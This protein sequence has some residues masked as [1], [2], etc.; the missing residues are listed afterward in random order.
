MSLLLCSAGHWTRI[1]VIQRSH[2]Q[3]VVSYHVSQICITPH[4]VRPIL[5]A[6]GHQEQ[7]LNPPLGVLYIVN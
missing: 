3:S 7:N 1:N 4:I 2:Y 6:L 5:I